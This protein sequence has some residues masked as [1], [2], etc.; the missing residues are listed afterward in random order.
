[1]KTKD[2][3]IPI[4]EEPAVAYANLVYNPMAVIFGSSYANPTDFDLLKLAR[5][6]IP[7]KT[8]TTLAKQVAL[9]LE[10]I[11]KV[12]HISERTLQR[13]EPSTLVRTEYSDRAIEL[14][15]L[16]ERGIAVLGS[17]K[18]FNSWLKT[19]N[20]ALGNETPLHLLDTHIGFTM[21]FDIL[22]RI[23]HGIF[24]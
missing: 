22:G 6:G 12:L 21:V 13:Y 24:S 23:E 5:K 11:A 15:R 19:P 9:T 18:A 14:A 7:K 10:E 20:Y 16:Y 2:S 4:L 8:L 3:K 17:Q 1:M